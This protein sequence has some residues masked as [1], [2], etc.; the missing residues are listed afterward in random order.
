M[1]SEYL[2]ERVEVQKKRGL[3]LF[4]VL[5]FVLPAYLPQPAGAATAVLSYGCLILVFGLVLRAPA[6]ATAYR[7]ALFGGE[8]MTTSL[9]FVFVR[10]FVLFCCFSVGLKTFERSFVLASPQ[11]TAE[12]RLRTAAHSPVFFT[13]SLIA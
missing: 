11:L 5:D 7:V 1:C 10:K 12:V 9:S 8:K 13:P 3:D 6:G 2:K 4:G